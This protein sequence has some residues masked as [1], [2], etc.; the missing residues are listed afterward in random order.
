MQANLFELAH[1]RQLHGKR[2]R[3]SFRSNLSWVQRY[4]L[5]SILKGH[6]GCVNTIQWSPDASLLCSGSDDRRVNIW[7]FS[8]GCVGNDASPDTSLTTLHRHNIF[9]AQM[10]LC[11]QRIVSCCAG[12]CVC[13]SYVQGSEQDR[14]LLYEPDMGHYLASKIAFSKHLGQEVFLTTFGDGCVRLFDLRTQSHRVAVD[15]NGLGLTGIEVRPTDGVTLA[16][17]GNDPFLRIYDLRALRCTQEESASGEQTPVVSLHTTGQLLASSHR[18][19]RESHSW[20]GTSEVGIS[21]VSWSTDGRLLLANYRGSDVTLFDMSLCIEAQG[22]AASGCDSSKVAKVPEVQEQFHLPAEVIHLNVLRSYEGRVNEQTC[23]KE[24]R[25]LCDS[26]AVGTGG[27]CGSFFIWEAATGTLLRKL[28]ADRCVVNCVAPHP[29]LPLVCTSGIDAE[30]KVWDV[31]DMRA[32]RTEVGSRAGRGECGSSLDWGRR[33]REGAG[34]ATAAEARARLQAAERLKQRGNELARTA[35][36]AEAL[37]KYEEALQELH[38]LAPNSG[39]EAEREALLTGCQLN[40]A[41]CHLNLEEFLLVVEQCTRV[42]ERQQNNVKARF[43]RATALG[44]LQ[45]FQRAFDD[46]EAALAIEPENAELTR[47][48]SKLRKRQREHRVCERSFYRRLF[49]SLTDAQF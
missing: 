12:G 26:A 41:W 38:F 42:L 29:E 43:R 9:D 22:A 49:S 24:V 13:L 27:D 30:V 25:F 32:P 3:T 11:Q 31:G 7:K 17:G 33:R 14:R 8:N 40:C 48:Q 45:E 19:R 28:P 6:R 2:L 4:E 44:K 16:I 37:G 23:A 34:N 36:W 39:V 1:L 21:G 5:V 46:I 20:T 10:T 47:L 35:G 15:A 18:S